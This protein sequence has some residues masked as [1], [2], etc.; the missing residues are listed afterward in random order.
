MRYV[1][2]HSLI[3]FD[4]TLNIEKRDWDYI[5]RLLLLLSS[6]CQIETQFR[7]CWNWSQSLAAFGLVSEAL[8]LGLAVFWG[9]PEWMIV[10]ILALYGLISQIIERLRDREVSKEPYATVTHPF[11]SIEQLAQVYHSTDFKKQTHDRSLNQRSNPFWLPI[12]F[13]LNFCFVAIISPFA[14]LSQSFPIRE[15]MTRI[16]TGT[17]A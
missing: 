6:D 15:E 16:R 4:A 2:E 5:Q 1:A 12:E 8:L 11:E 10:A 17:V 13:M 7:S 3:Y 9:Q 14:L